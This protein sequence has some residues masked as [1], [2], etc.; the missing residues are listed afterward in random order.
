M[1]AKG[2]RRSSP[3]AQP[4][5]GA[6]E[7]YAHKRD[8]ARSP[9]PPPA[10]ARRPRRQGLRF[11]VQKHAARHLH[12]DFRLELEGSLKSWAVPKGPSLDPQVKRLAVQVEDHPLAYAGFE[13]H[14]PEGQY[15][16][17][18]IIV[19]DQ[20]L[21]E[22]L[23]ADPA[24]AWRAG[25]LGFRLQGEKLGG[26][27]ALIRTRGGDGR[28]WLLIKEQ[29]ASARAE[30][31]YDVLAAR[32]ESVLSGAG[33][34]G[35]EEGPAAERGQEAEAARGR[36]GALP[37]WIAPALATLVDAPPPGD[38]HWEPKFDGYRLLARV[39]AGEVRL[40]TRNRQDW[41]GRLP[42]LAAAVQALGLE[43]AWLDGEIV[44]L[45]ARGVPDFQALQNSLEQNGGGELRYALFDLPYHAGEDLRALPLEA[46]RE[47]LRALLA[48]RGGPLLQYSGDL[49]VAPREV[50]AGACKLGLEGI[51]GKQAG[52]PYRSG[53]S[54]DW[55]K[56]KCGLRQEFLILGY[57]PPRGSRRGF[58]ALLL[59]LREGGRLRYAGRVGS[60]FS[61][62]SLEA[63]QRRMQPLVRVIP[64]L[65]DLPAGTSTRGVTWL[66][67]RLV[68]EVA[69]A[70]WTR[71]GLVRQGVFHGLR[72]DKPAAQV[73][74]E[75][76]SPVPSADLPAAG[77]AARKSA[78]SRAP[79]GIAISHAER[80]IDKASG[81]TKGEL[82][83]FYCRIAPRLLPHLAGRPLSI[84]R[85]PTGLEG[86]RFF[87]RHGEALALPGVRLLPP[88]LDPGKKPL[89]AIDRV[90]GL[91]GAVQMG[92]IEFHTWNATVDHLERPD[93]L[94]F[95]LDPDPALPWARVVEAT[96]LLLTLLDELGLAAF[97]KT[98]GGKGMHVVVPL[99]RHHP[100]EELQDF[101]RAVSRH[102]ARILSGR[103]AERMGPRNRV[104][105][106]FVDY[107]RNQR[108][109]STVAAYS[110]R[111]RPGL[112]VSVP[113]TRGELE[114]IR[115]SG[116]W[117]VHTLAERL[118]GLKGDP[119]AGYA[120]RQRVTREMRERLESQR[121]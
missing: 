33:L 37:E 121:R 15:G 85:A 22:P 111:A 60:G 72:E 74:R 106:I 41:T 31:D 97:L 105:R 32:P 80:V 110:V 4:Q 82:A 99:A 108:G 114:E 75:E 27:W 34:P 56:L 83:A 86:E 5:S 43:S 58:G 79:A 89:M 42:A 3:P 44:V 8:F 48:A 84:L 50:L 9:E 116:Q 36:A 13:G 26:R 16:G 113:I 23:E 53:R 28:Q 25:K 64:A 40:Y 92:T 49:P 14:I 87:Q 68:C 94:V 52:S 112:P 46:R 19:W 61:G 96:R 30:S 54:R 69:F 71:D 67:P 20:G 73:A 81:Y 90:D 29:D 98:S 76:A 91:V 78:R 18:D 35:G 59:G 70:R 10:R 102:L 12:Y 66:E 119:W 6:L 88:Q 45:D 109:A 39:G 77:G 120:H 62:A 93:R 115:G 101:S 47:R 17:G 118:E 117:T 63:L 55:V 38:W 7:D 2:S 103:F 104:G 24:A 65:A 100:W 107:L 21:W 51:I 57:T 1:A 95:D 11:V